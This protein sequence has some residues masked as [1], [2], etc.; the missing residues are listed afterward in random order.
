MERWILDVPFPDTP[1]WYLETVESTMDSAYEMVCA[2]PEASV[3]ITS[4]YQQAGRGR[5]AGRTWVSEPGDSLMFTYAFPRSCW[6][7]PVQLLPIL[8]GLGIANFL[9]DRFGLAPAIK[10]PNDMIVQQRKICG[11]LC[12]ARGSHLLVGVG[13]NCRQQTFPVL[14]R[15]GIFAPASIA[16]VT[17]LPIPEYRELLG[18]VLTAL[19]QAYADDA[20]Q[21][22]VNSLLFGRDTQ[23]RFDPGPA[24]T[25]ESV[26]SGIVQGYL[27]GIDADGALCMDLADGTSSVW[28]AGELLM[29]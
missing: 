15:A 13:L 20:W 26:S 7:R 3:I 9:S 11:I 2:Q 23:V 12:E 5:I 27:A 16:Q 17:D 8:T 28:Y 19:H 25:T 21:D 14:S 18:G 24:R 6:E 1:V 10:W 29:N 22:H 4:S